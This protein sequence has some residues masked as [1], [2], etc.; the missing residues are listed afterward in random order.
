MM[1]PKS[2]FLFTFCDPN[3]VHILLGY[4]SDINLLCANINTTQKNT[5]ALLD[6]SK[7]QNVGAVNFC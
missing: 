3:C 4:V 1:S 2:Y 6:S 7:E 5:Q